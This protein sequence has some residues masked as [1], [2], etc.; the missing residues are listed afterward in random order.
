MVCSR[1]SVT[2]STLMGLLAFMAVL[3]I[4]ATV[5]FAMMPTLGQAVWS[6]GFAESFAHGPW[7][8]IYAR[9]FGL[10]DPAPIAFGLAGAW[11]A[12]V[13]I[14]LGLHPADA[15]V[16]VLAFWLAVA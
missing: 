8:E 16:A 3:L 13:L 1:R 4:H 5:P 11:P 10:P 15:Y 14:R 7:Y 12:S 2:R 9:H 6:M